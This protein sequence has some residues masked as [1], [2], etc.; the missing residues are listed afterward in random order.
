MLDLMRIIR[1][2]GASSALRESVQS[3]QHLDQAEAAD[4]GADAL[5]QSI[6]KPL[7]DSDEPELVAEFQRLALGAEDRAA[8][9]PARAL[10]KIAIVDGWLAGLIEGLTF[11]ERMRVEAEAY[12]AAR[13]KNERPVGFAS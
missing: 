1:L 7:Q 12:A 2:R 8:T 6:S 4:R 13:V 3:A 11:K 9:A 10:T 5:I